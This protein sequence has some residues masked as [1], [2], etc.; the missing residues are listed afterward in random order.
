M[1]NKPF[2]LFIQPLKGPRRLFGWRAY[3]TEQAAVDA[4]KSLLN[5]ECYL[6]EIDNVAR[7]EGCGMTSWVRI[8]N[9]WLP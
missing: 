1:I 8:E 4:F 6:G 7:I 3:W 9:G 5:S 2:V